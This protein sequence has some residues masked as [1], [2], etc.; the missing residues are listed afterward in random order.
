MWGIESSNFYDLGKIALRNFFRGM[1]EMMVYYWKR[2]KRILR[3]TWI[4]HLMSLESPVSIYVL[5]QNIF[6]NQCEK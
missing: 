3:I 6:H 4:D 5:Y 2:M 1:S